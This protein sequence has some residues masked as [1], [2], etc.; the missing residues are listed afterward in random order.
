MVRQSKIE[1]DGLDDL[2]MGHCSGC[3][4]DGYEGWMITY[5]RAGAYISIRVADLRQLVDEEVLPA[6]INTMIDRVDLYT[7]ESLEVKS[8]RQPN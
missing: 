2:E 1:G 6:Y 8:D 7:K 3:A 5:Q 4:L